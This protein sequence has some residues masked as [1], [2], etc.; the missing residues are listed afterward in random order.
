MFY[1]NGVEIQ[2]VRMPAA[3][4][5]ITY[6]TLATATPCGGDATCADVFTISGNLITNLVNGTNVLAVEVHQTSS[7]GN[8]DMVF[9]S[10]LFASITTATL[11]TVV[12]TTPANNQ[13]LAEG[14]SVTINTAFTGVS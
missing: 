8:A 7:P 12:I 4:T 14:A 9:A 2:R 1:L 3:P 11:P 10:A 6:T 5:A 13:S